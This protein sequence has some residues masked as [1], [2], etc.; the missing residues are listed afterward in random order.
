MQLYILQIIFQMNNFDVTIAQN[1]H[2]AYEFVVESLQNNTKKQSENEFHGESL[3]DLIVL[4]LNMPISD[5]YEAC[6][7]IVNLYG[8]NNKLFKMQ[9]NESKD[10][11]VGSG[12]E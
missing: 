5:G 2:E 10:S 12:S 1:G 9:K 4:D 6:K 7:N 11:P 3:F 8:D